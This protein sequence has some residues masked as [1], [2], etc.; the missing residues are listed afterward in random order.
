MM[1]NKQNVNP[2][3]K[4]KLLLLPPAIAA[5]ALITTT[6][7][8]EVALTAQE[9]SQGIATA[10]QDTTTKKGSTSISGIPQEGV[11][12][13]VDGKRMDASKIKSIDPNAIL[14]ID[15]LKG[16]Q[17][18]TLAAE[19]NLKGVIAITT[20]AG[21]SS[22]E[23][24]EMQRKI[25]SINISAGEPGTGVLGQV[26]GP[27]GFVQS[28]SDALY[29]LNGK[30]I[31]YKEMQAINPKDVASVEVLKDEKAVQQYGE[32]GK[33]GVVKITSKK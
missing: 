9:L 19:K 1:M 31:S 23:A 22:A 17:A 2:L 13:L 5:L 11:V 20:K 21:Q 10:A 14:K 30:E 6:S 3:Q 28:P 15:V 33:N 8:A 16:E 32:K 29:I 4:L 25:E 12:Y 26:S 24:K 18:Q 27:D 7:K